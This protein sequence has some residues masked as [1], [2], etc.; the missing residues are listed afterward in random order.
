MYTVIVFHNVFC[1]FFFF[2]KEEDLEKR[3]D[4]RYVF[5]IEWTGLGCEYER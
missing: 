2:I 3:N 1:D 5:Q 4:S